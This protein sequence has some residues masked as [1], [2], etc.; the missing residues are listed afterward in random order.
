MSG[1][2]GRCDS[3]NKS[4]GSACSAGLA[5]LLDLMS[6]LGLTGWIGFVNPT[7]LKKLSCFPV[8]T[9]PYAQFTTKSSFCIFHPVYAI[10]ASRYDKVGYSGYIMVLNSKSCSSQNREAYPHS[11]RFNHV[12]LLS[13]PS[14]L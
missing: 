7:S 6:L 14:L 4:R 8:S 5:S 10:D 12:V 13:I 1:R 11:N 9:N 3:S 2:F